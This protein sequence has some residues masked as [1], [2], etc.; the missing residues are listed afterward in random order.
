[1]LITLLSA[2]M[3]NEEDVVV[4]QKPVEARRL[5]TIDDA[6]MQM[7]MQDEPTA[8]EATDETS[9]SDIVNSNKGK[10]AKGLERWL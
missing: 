8:I 7:T 3:N 5:N 10:I 2:S 4:S 6:V 9:L 1:M